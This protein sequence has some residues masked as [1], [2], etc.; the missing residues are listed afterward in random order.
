[1]LQHGDD[2][3]DALDLL[4][5]ATLIARHRYPL[6]TLGSVEEQ[7]DDLA[8][9]VEGRLP[10]GSGGGGPPLYPLKILQAISAVFAERGFRGNTDDYYAPDN[11]CINR[12]LDTRLGIPITLGLVYVQV[13]P[14]V[15]SAKGLQCSQCLQ[16][17]LS[18]PVPWLACCSP[19]T[20][21]QVAQRLGL[22]MVGVNL[23][24]HFFVAP[25]DPD[26]QFLVDAFHGVRGGVGEGVEVRCGAVR[27]GRG[28]VWCDVGG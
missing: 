11:S 1:M 12:V 26:L 4:E 28:E 27:C 17:Q 6:L 25:A 18:R 24:G 21:L 15:F 16:Y 9:Q 5:G 8:V 14:A 20:L 2:D 7:L 10:G 22:P 3:H 13:G 23:P 19:T